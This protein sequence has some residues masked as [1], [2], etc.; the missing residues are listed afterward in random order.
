MPAVSLPHVIPPCPSLDRQQRISTFSVGL[1]T[2]KPSSQRPAFSVK[3]S[4]PQFNVQ[5][6]IST[7]RHDDM[8][9]PSPL[10]TFVEFTV[11]PRIITLS[12][13]MGLTFHST[14]FSN[15]TPCT[16]TFLQFIGANDLGRQNVRPSSPSHRRSATGVFTDMSFSTTLLPLRRR[17]MAASIGGPD[18]TPSPVRAMFLAPLA[19][20]NA[21]AP[22]TSTPSWRV[23]T[24]G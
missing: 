19:Y 6:S 21:P 7:L 24:A 2:R 23:N 17:R 4:S 10:G 20:I 13:Y 16:K 18:I 9:M 5:Y 1:F 22:N 12:Q 3:Q 8:S 15:V 11:M 14:L